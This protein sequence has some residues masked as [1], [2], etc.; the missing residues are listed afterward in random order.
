MISLKDLNDKFIGVLHISYG[1]E[2]KL[3]HN[4]WIFL[5]QKV[6]VIGSLLTKYLHQSNNIKK[7]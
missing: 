1:T 7:R 2:Y 3:T 5:R 4:E 6:G